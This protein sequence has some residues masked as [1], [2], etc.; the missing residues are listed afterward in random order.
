[1]Y[2]VVELDK[3]EGLPGKNCYQAKLSTVGI[4]KLSSLRL[5]KVRINPIRA[6]FLFEVKFIPG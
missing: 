2:S 3:N 5:K 6:P 4:A 1:M